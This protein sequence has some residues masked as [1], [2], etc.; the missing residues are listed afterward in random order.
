MKKLEISCVDS[1]WKHPIEKTDRRA[2]LWTFDHPGV[3]AIEGD[4]A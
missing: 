4:L 3:S 1:C 2:K